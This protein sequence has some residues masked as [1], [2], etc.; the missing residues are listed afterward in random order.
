MYVPR[1]PV[2]IRAPGTPTDRPM[3]DFEKLSRNGPNDVLRR[4]V[5]P[6][7]DLSLSNRSCEPLAIHEW[8]HKG[9]HS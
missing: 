1:G 3:P 6:T 2:E 8:M 7:D 9:H 4:H 5:H